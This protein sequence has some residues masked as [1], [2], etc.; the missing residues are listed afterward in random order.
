MLGE[1]PKKKQKGE[2]LR[3][4]TKLRSQLLERDQRLGLKSKGKSF[5]VSQGVIVKPQAIV[6]IIKGVISSKV[7]I[8]EVRCREENLK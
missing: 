7:R 8:I 3:E 1:F 2:K 4:A 6:A 5:A